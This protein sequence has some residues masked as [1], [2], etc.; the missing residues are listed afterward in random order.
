METCSVSFLSGFEP[1]GKQLFEPS[2]LVTLM[3]A[4]GS[5]RLDLD[6]HPAFLL[7]LP[8]QPTICIAPPSIATIH[9]TF[10]RE[11]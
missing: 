1:T 6:F 3:V 9:P 7:L 4:E 2:K 11:T 5:V 10:A 8:R